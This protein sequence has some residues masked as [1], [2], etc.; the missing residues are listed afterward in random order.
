MEP[1]VEIKNLSIRFPEGNSTFEAVKGI[2]FS[3]GKGEI[4]GVVG[5][6]GSGKSMSALA[7]MGLLPKDAEIASGSLCFQGEDLVTM[8]PEKRRQLCGSKMAMVFQEP[9]TAMDPLM[10][11]GPQ[12]EEALAVHTQLTKEQRR[13]RA[14]EALRDVDLPAPEEIYRKYPHECSG[15]QLQRVMIAAAIVTDPHL[16]LLDEPTTALDVTVQAQI[17]AL[18]RRLNRERGISMLLISHNLQVVRRICSRVAVMQ[19]GHIV[20]EGAPE[21]L[22]TA[23]QHPYTAELINAIPRRVRRG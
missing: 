18:L 15:G 3:I 9:M 13:T 22:F 19:R 6:S 17:L 1:L 7:L 8:K 5:E 4:V 21:Q 20:E 23:P 14:L 11:I 2:S 10:R 12:V 16:L